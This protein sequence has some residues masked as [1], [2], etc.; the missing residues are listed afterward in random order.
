MIHDPERRWKQRQERA[1]S[2]KKR[3]TLQKKILLIAVAVLAVLVAGIILLTR[4]CRNSQPPEATEPQQTETADAAKDQEVTSIHIVAGGD[5]NVSDELIVSGGAEYNFT[6][7]FMDVVPVLADADLSVVNFEGTFAG[8]PYGGESASAPD[9]L[10]Q[11]LRRGGVDI[12]QLANSYSIFQGALGLQKTI[13]ATRTAGLTPVGVHATK[14]EARHSDNYT[15]R[16]INGIRIALVAF[17]KGMKNSDRILPVIEGCVNVLYT[18]YDTTYQ[19]VDTKGITQVLEEVAKEKPDY[20]IALLHW[21]SE[22]TDPISDSQKKIA[23]IMQENGVNAI[24]GTHSHYVQKLEYNPL[25]GSFIA[26]SLGD[27]L[28]GT[29]RSGSEYSILLDLEIQKNHRTGKTSLAGFTYTPIFTVREEGK[30]LR[31]MRIR[32][33]MAAYEQ[34]YIGRISEKTYGDMQYALERI[35]SRVAGE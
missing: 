10:A 1:E 16:E 28:S 25:D 24:I 33:T 4:S 5:L 19:T 18:D 8:A 2:R 27:F 13:A 17:T 30:P 21:G 20:T 23:S 29:T 26:Y 15:I 14:T 6:E 3:Q 9:T 31:V 7:T 22:F 32:E 35:E 34:N 11:T 12:L